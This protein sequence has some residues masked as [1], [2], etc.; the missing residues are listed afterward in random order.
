MTA[1]ANMV[2]APWAHTR[3]GNTMYKNFELLCC[4][5]ETDINQLCLNK[6]YECL[7]IY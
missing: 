3:K 4:T 5:L 6:K 1:G 7:Y 2:I